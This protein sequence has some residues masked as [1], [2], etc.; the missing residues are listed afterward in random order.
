MYI[1]SGSPDLQRIIFQ[2]KFAPSIQHFDTV[3]KN[4]ARVVEAAHTLGMK[5]FATE[6]YP[7]VRKNRAR[8]FPLWLSK[9]AIRK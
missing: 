7:K 6:Q 8:C 2:E 3:V 5:C 1:P 4:A 9:R